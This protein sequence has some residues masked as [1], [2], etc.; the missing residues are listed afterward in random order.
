MV[1]DKEE[2]GETWRLTE[3]FIRSKSHIAEAVRDRIN[4]LNPNCDDTTNEAVV[5]PMDGYH[6]PR[7]DLKEMAEEG[8][9][10]ETDECGLQAKLSY[11]KLLARRGAAFTYDPARFIKDLKSAKDNGEGSFPVYSRAKH[12]P[13]EDGVKIEKHNKIILVEG[14][15]LLCTDDP[16]WHELE[17]LW[18]DKWYIDVSLEETKRRLVERHLKTWN[19]EKTKIFGGSGPKAAARKAESNDILNAK[20]IRKHAKKHASLIISNEKVTDTIKQG[21]KDRKDILNDS[22]IYS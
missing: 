14:L 21:R 20:S 2:D 7:E 8:S 22:T 12:D 15:Y 19:E 3:V 10:F 4:E 1:L 11:E 13:V 9:A 5:I 18:D 16:N 6:I 17:A